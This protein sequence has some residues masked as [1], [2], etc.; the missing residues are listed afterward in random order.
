V[1]HF[2]AQAPG[3]D[4][5]LLR[6][7]VGNDDSHQLSVARIRLQTR[8]LQR[9]GER[10]LIT[11]DA[12]LVDSVATAPPVFETACGGDAAMVQHN[13]RVARALDIYISS[14][15]PSRR[16]RWPAL[17]ARTFDGPG[18]DARALLNDVEADG[19]VPADKPP[20]GGTSEQELS[21]AD[22]AVM[23]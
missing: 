21:A 15:S 4:E 11:L 18:R 14:G 22:A 1:A 20:A 9:F 2:H 8:H 5:Y 3:D 13:N 12:N 7:A 16:T 23:R 6:A 10:R 19:K 17:P